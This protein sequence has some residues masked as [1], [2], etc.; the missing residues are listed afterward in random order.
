MTRQ[1]GLQSGTGGGFRLWR[2]WEKSVTKGPRSCEK[3][4]GGIRTHQCTNVCC[5]GE[6]G[7]FHITAFVTPLFR[8]WSDKR[9]ES[10]E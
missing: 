5:D 10:E 4:R 3:V 7:L 9:T 1:D 6:V 8:G 2:K